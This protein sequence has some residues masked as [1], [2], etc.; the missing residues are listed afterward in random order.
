MV[1][2]KNFFSRRNIIIFSIIIVVVGGAVVFFATRKNNNTSYVTDLVV[3]KDLLE[4]VSEVGTVE[5]PSQIDLNFTTPGKLAAKFVGVGAEIKTGEVLA[6]LDFQTLSIQRDQ[7]QAN[8]AKLLQGATPAQIAVA[9]AQVDQANAAN[10]AAVDNLNKTN[11]SVAEDIKQ[12]QANLNDLQG[13]TAT[14]TTFQQAVLSGQTALANAQTDYQKSI[15]SATQN[16]LNDL[17]GKLSSAVSALDGVN[18]IITDDNVK[19]YL[20]SENTTYLSL[21][22]ND[23]DSAQ[24]LL[25]TANGSV[26]AVD[27][28]KSQANLDQAAGDTLICLKKISDCLD[29]LYNA[30][31]NSAISSQTVLA[32]DKSNTSAQITAINA[33]ISVI[34][35]DQQNMDNAYLSYSTNVTAAQNGLSSAQSA[36]DQ[37]ITNA[38]NAL[39]T[40]QVGGNQEIS[41][42]SNGV[43]TAKQ[44]LDVAQKQLAQLKAPPRVEDVNLAQAALDLA[45]KQIQDDMITSPIDGQVIKD[46][47]EVGEQ[48]NLATPVFSVLAENDLEVSVE[49]SES[50][51]AKLKEGDAVE[52]TLDAFGPDQKFNGSVYFIDPAST[53]IQDVTY[54][55]V[56]IKFTDPAAQL[57]AIKPGMTA[58]VTVIADKRTNVL[59][60]PERAVIVN[61]DGS[62]IVRILTKGKIT[63]VPVKVGLR[64]D[65]GSVEITEG[66]LQT[67][68]TVVVFINAQ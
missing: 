34:T 32:A 52:I 12:A 42:A 13:L 37:A 63:E 36:W 55:R 50:D 8:L 51:I 49:I 11:L 22:K 15:D 21:T 45:N 18:V 59:T 23:Y 46:N 16:L 48:T 3:K 60:V 64:G 26:A 20:S 25:T 40:A 41:A 9:Q 68:Q 6:Q 19:N 67:G 66:N 2:K 31:I 43:S 33:A 10:A 5:S 65:D 17:N 1:L 4:T 28:V 24:T 30:L 47:Y 53:V 14:V 39:A 62:K 7:A 57:A 38:K 27:G 61:T 35:V 44:A 56:K 29:N 58:N 54:Y